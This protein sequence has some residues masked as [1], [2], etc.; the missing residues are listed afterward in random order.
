MSDDRNTP[1]ADHAGLDETA[2]ADHDGPRIVRSEDLLRGKR[3]VWI[4]HGAEMYRLR[5]TSSGK[6]YL[7]K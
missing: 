2:A 6:L 4:A 5:V 7:T 3:E 1:E